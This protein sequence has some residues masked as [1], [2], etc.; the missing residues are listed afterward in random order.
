MAEFKN[1]GIVL[2]K[3]K[4]NNINGFSYLR[5]SLNN[6]DRTL[7]TKLILS[8]LANGDIDIQYAT[9]LECHTLVKNILGVDY[10]NERLSWENLVFLFESSVLIEIISHGV[11]HDD[12]RVR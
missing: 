5:Y 8:L 12:K 6:E 9:Y 11:T 7:A 3:S 10:K 1:S 2:R 4:E